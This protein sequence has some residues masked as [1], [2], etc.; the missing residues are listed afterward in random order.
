M[1][2]FFT[3]TLLLALIL[4]S[5]FLYGQEPQ[6]SF[7][8]KNVTVKEALEVLKKQSNY[9]L[10]FNANDIRLQDRITVT[11]HQQSLWEALE[12]ILRG[13]DL[14]FTIKDRHIQIFKSPGASGRK[15]SG[16]VLDEN[17]QPLPGATVVIKELQQGTTT[18]VE[19]RFQLHA[20][21]NARLVISFLGYKSVELVAAADM[22]VLLQPD[23]IRLQ[24]VVV[25][26][27]Q[28]ISRER[29]T[30][31][32]DI[33][34]KET[35]EKPS[36]SLAGR[37]V[38]TAAGLQATLDAE[39]N[40]RFEIRGQSSILTNASPLVVVDGFAIE[41]DFNSVNPNDVET[42]SILKDAAAASIWGARAANGVIVVTTKKARTGKPLHVEVS[43]F[44]R[45]GSRPDL[46][47][48]LNQASSEEM[49]EF[50]QRQFGK[51]SNTLVA[52][53]FR[54]NV[55]RHRS[56]AI[57]LYNEYI[58][59]YI[60]EDDL[61]KGLE[62]LRKQSNRGQIK[63][64]LF[65]VPVYQQY[66]LS[67]SGATEKMSN[68]LSVLYER[69]RRTAVK[70]RNDN[71][72]VNYRG[73]MSLFKWLDVSLS[74]MLQ[75]KSANTS[76]IAIGD[77]RQLA[78]YDLLLNAD[79][80]YT[81]V[82]TSY[83]TPLIERN[84]PKEL[85][86]YADWSYNPITE[87]HN[88]KLTSKQLNARLQAGL[89]FK[90]MEGLTF[91]SKIQ[92]EV[93]TYKNR[94]LYN[95]KTWMVRQTVNE[96]TTWD[97]NTDE[98]DVNLPGGSILDEYDTETSTYDFRNQL[99]FNR[100]FAG[101]HE[102]SFLAGVEVNQVK[103]KYHASPRT[104]GYDDEHLTVGLFP[105]GPGGSPNY[106]YNWLGSGQTFG[107]TNTY[108]ESTDRYFSFYANLAYTFDGKY[109]VS[110]SFRNDA[111]NFI[112]D[113]P[114]Y[115]YSPFWSVGMSW[116]MGKE[117][118][119][120]NFGGLDMLKVRLT[121]GY[122]GNSDNSTS[123]KPLMAMTGV[124]EYTGEMT[125]ELTSR[126]NP[127]L[128]WEKTGTVDVG[129][130]FSFFSGK[131]GGKFDFYDKHGKDIL[132]EVDIAQ[133]NGSTREKINNAEIRNRGIEIELNSR[134]NIYG[135]RISWS[136]SLNFAY[137]K[138]KI[139]KLFRSS[140]PYWVLVGQSGSYSYVEGYD[141][142]EL[143]SYGYG[144]VQNIGT[145]DEPNM[146]PVIRMNDGQ[147]AG[148]SN[149]PVAD[150]LTF[151]RPQGTK[152]APYTVG[153]MNS[154]KIYD[155]DL[156]FILTGKFGHV[157][158]RTGFNYPT[159]SGDSYANKM[160][161]EVLHADGSRMVPL[162]ANDND[163]TYGKYSQFAYYMDYL[164]ESANHVRLTEVN[165]TWHLP[166]PALNTLGFTRASVY[167]QGN[168]LLTFKNTK[169]NEDPEFRFGN[170]KLQPTWLLGVKLEF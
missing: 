143:W 120:T 110:G 129:V 54:D 169:H 162:P 113:D 46:D 62:R 35:L 70:N 14:Q 145:P 74:T 98:I 29:A 154:F 21:E 114:K 86:P 2:K 155:F 40:A 81:D 161:T 138:N 133:A 157:F 103:E 28:T 61:N 12:A 51:W 107:Y 65:Q 159:I 153:M 76:G 10:W 167:V 105:N 124:N 166:R 7:D 33:I 170:L 30:G 3:A 152:V 49:V 68:N 6:V 106:L 127:A 91:D 136:G 126:G 77:L 27:Y 9:S 4:F 158:R 48:V 160:L 47:Y 150:G 38:G 57:T 73:S 141:A 116:N 97:R 139:L 90:L 151:C 149:I 8:L 130:D 92:Y 53:N 140:Q 147:V 84:V 36:A 87:V 131:L 168:N 32:F 45:I 75:Y 50:E 99:N 26:G 123:F 34:G 1:K 125:G 52:D 132:A 112:S 44:T 96:S 37:L 13:Q 23:A 5:P 17:A 63:D 119:M 109:T 100:V 69:D 71:F 122:N 117:D 55:T 31:S 79:G 102:V 142:N 19:G 95:E 15:V 144:G 20:P 24:D 80:S 88:R 39:G 56:Q 164:T 59:R 148:F 156:S 18:D 134:Q 60:G 82:N 121:Y 93:F 72:M 11:L 118:F 108:E 42:V 67:V 41:G 111:S 163:R 94:K 83:Y 137:N 78:P 58:L 85:F 25:T 22:R 104:Y 146:Q 43:A 128:R 66:N 101:R 135:N 64:R 16:V 89:T 115:R 165:L